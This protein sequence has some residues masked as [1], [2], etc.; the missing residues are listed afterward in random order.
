MVTCTKSILVVL[1]GVPL[2]RMGSGKSS[3]RYCI[4]IWPMS[5]GSPHEGMSLWKSKRTVMD[6]TPFCKGLHA[7]VVNPMHVMGSSTSTI[8]HLASSKGRRYNGFFPN[9]WIALLRLKALVPDCFSFQCA[10]SGHNERYIF[11]NPHALVSA[12]SIGCHFMI[13]RVRRRSFSS[14]RFIHIH[15]HIRGVFRL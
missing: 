1:G 4:A 9:A 15:R 2:K 6:F 14:Q 7:S 3:H 5:T 8:P 12:T 11:F 10:S 13:R